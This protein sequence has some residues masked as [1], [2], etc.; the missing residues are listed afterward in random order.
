MDPSGGRETIDL[1]G[2]TISDLH[3]SSSIERPFAVQKL[4]DLIPLGGDPELLS[5]MHRDYV[6]LWSARR[7]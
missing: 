4:H 6:I 1:G 3:S 2:M 7:S 5:L